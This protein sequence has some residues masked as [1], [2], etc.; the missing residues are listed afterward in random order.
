MAKNYK[1]DSDLLPSYLSKN[2]SSYDFDDLFVPIGSYTSM[3]TPN[4]KINKFYYNSNNTKT[5]VFSKFMHDNHTSTQ[6]PIFIT[7]CPGYTPQPKLIYRGTA[8]HVENDLTSITPKTFEC[9]YNS[10]TSKYIIIWWSNREIHMKEINL[11][12]LSGYYPVLDGVE[13]KNICERDG[14]YTTLFSLESDTAPLLQK[15]YFEMVAGGGGGGGSHSGTERNRASGG[16]GGGAAV[17]GIIDYDDN[18]YQFILTPAG[19]GGASES[20]GRGGGD[21]AICWQTSEASYAYRVNPQT[22]KYQDYWDLY[23]SLL[24]L[25]GGSGGPKGRSGGI[26]SDYVA[27]GGQ[28]YTASYSVTF[29]S[30]YPNYVIDSTSISNKSSYIGN[31]NEWK[32]LAYLSIYSGRNGGVGGGRVAGDDNCPAG[33]VNGLTTTFYKD[34]TLT[35]QK[36]TSGGSGGGAYGGG[37]SALGGGDVIGGAYAGPG[38]GG[39]GR[40]SGTTAGIYG[41]PAQLKLY[42]YTP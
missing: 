14:S 29:T 18:V 13:I 33:D 35:R 11:T 17:A 7:G 4:D 24:V 9:A 36:S 42:I 6:S 41:G 16:G 20:N 12:N 25:E 3:G 32:N 30:R 38:G 8:P 26:T 27:P 15:I 19:A 28:I 5:D 39:S 40:T 23:D 21:C 34:N 31:F 2:A 10:T 22:G 1:I 37:A